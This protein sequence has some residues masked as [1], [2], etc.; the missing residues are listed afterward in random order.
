MASSNLFTYANARKAY[1][2]GLAGAIAT[3]STISVA[4]LFVNGSFDANAFLASAAAVVGAFVI[5]FVTTWLSSNATPVTDASKHEDGTTPAAVEDDV[6]PVFDDAANK[7]VETSPGVTTA[8][9]E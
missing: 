2:A 7:S 5:T 9:S 8:S 6:T 3:A 1:N 4:T